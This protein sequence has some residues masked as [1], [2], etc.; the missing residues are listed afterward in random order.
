MIKMTIYSDILD[1]RKIENH[2]ANKDVLIIKIEKQINR[3]LQQLM[4]QGKIIGKIY[5]GLRT[6]GLQPARL[7]QIA[8]E[9]KVGLPPWPAL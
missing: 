1:A 5:Q 8:L 9:D 6:T 2:N 4:K 3:N 7:Y